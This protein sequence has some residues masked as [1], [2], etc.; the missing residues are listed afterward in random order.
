MTAM[1]GWRC[2]L[3]RFT[4]R[5]LFCASKLTMSASPSAGG[6]SSFV[7]GV[8]LTL[9]GGLCNGTWTLVTKPNAPAF[10]N[11]VRRTSRDNGEGGMDSDDSWAWENAWCA[12]QTFAPLINAVVCASAAHDAIAYAWRG[13]DGTVA[14]AVVVCS[15]LWGGG[16]VGFGK[17]VHH[18]G[19]AT[20]TSVC[21]GIM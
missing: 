15:L 6:A 17:A 12:I 11:A 10:L 1:T 3:G 7:L 13:A 14:A 2:L 8:F 4:A 21:M 5:I 9:L 19:V 16:G 18:L 20:G